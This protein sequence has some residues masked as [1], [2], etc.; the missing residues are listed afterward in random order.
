MP[1][2]R[3]CASGVN[4]FSLF[5][6]QLRHAKEREHGVL[7]AL[8]RSSYLRK[9]HGVLFGELRVLVDK[10]VNVKILNNFFFHRKLSLATEKSPWSPGDAGGLKKLPL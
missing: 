1:Q 8:L 2:G 10:T 4:V 9:F 7:P 3:R 6:P 5:V